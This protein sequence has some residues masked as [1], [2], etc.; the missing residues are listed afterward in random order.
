MSR[1]VTLLSMDEGREEDGVSDEEDRSV[2]PDHVPVPLL[3]IELHS[4]A[5]RVTNGVSASTLST[6]GTKSNSD[7]GSL[8]NSGQECSLAVLTHILGYFKVS[9]G[10]S[11]F[12]MHDLQHT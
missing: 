11:T 4:E 10:S 8:P 3:G 12:S 7:I 5:S 9:K 1:R 2:V 6:D